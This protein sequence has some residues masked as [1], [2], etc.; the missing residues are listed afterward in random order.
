MD[1]VVERAVGAEQVRI[2]A[3]LQGFV[4]LAALIAL[5]LFFM[6][7]TPFTTPQA[8]WSWLGPVNDWLAV[9]GAVPWIVAMVLL[10]RYV[11]SGSWMWTLTLAACVGAAAIAVVTLLLLT[12]VAGL[13]LQSVV[14]L[15]A[16]VVAF[17]WAAVAASHA[18]DSAAVPAWIAT[19]A[20]AMLVA[21][22]VAAILAGIA[23]AVG[24]EST[25][26]TTLYVVAGVIGGLAW[27]AFPVWWLAVAS[28]LR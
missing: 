26:Q 20:I 7:A 24:A 4:S 27:C 23:F 25:L 21:L 13:Q 28:T 6:L 10:A 2:W 11:A 18:R 8:R 9:I 17:V 5:A 1:V 3:G 16:T 19:L 22:L 14:S 15:A 12:G